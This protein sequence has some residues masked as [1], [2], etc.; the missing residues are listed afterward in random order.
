M[1]FYPIDTNQ[2]KLHCFNHGDFTDDIPPLLRNDSEEIDSDHEVIDLSVLVTF[3]HE[4]WIQQ[5]QQTLRELNFDAHLAVC[6]AEVKH[7]ISA[8][9]D[10][11]PHP[12][13]VTDMT[14]Y[15]LNA[16]LDGWID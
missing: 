16:I 2:Q 12:E 1:P 9:L 15:N 7:G 3:S 11:M 8:S 14:I 13:P 6:E 5:A 4:W 10:V